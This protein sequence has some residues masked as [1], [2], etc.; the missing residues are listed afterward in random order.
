[1]TVPL[2][3]HQNT[4]TVNGEDQSKTQVDADDDATVDVLGTEVLDVE[5]LPFTGAQSDMLFVAS[6]MLLLAGFSIIYV[7]RK[8]EDS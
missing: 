6:M 5:V 7:T 8:R 1:M 4:V 2:G 3:V